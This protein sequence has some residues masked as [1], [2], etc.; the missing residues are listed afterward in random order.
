MEKYMYP[1][2]IL[3][4]SKK[5]CDVPEAYIQVQMEGR[6]GGYIRVQMEGPSGG[7]ITRSNGG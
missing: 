3:R 4:K 2:E 7:Y 6:S 5:V 1:F